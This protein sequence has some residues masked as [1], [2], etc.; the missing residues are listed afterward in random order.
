MLALL[1]NAAEVATHFQSI[2]AEIIRH[3]PTLAQRRRERNVGTLQ[4]LAV[5]VG[6]AEC[7]ALWAPIR[8]ML[9][10]VTALV[11]ATIAYLLVVDVAKYPVK[12]LVITLKH[13]LGYHDESSLAPGL[14]KSSAP[15]SLFRLFPFAIVLI[16]SVLIAVADRATSDLAVSASTMAICGLL[17]GLA[18]MLVGA[19]L[20]A[21]PIHFDANR[22]PFDAVIS[23]L[24]TE[25]AQDE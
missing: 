3:D 18:A 24:R 13:Y 15:T 19:S 23:K 20:S 12:F 21:R 16:G 8:L 6:I 1:W 25:G 9:V 4:V 10:P 5:M 7:F 2:D 22:T 14:I 17:T 11:A